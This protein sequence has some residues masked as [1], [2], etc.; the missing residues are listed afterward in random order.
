MTITF[1]DLATGERYLCGTVNADGTVT[2]SILLPGDNDDATWKKQLAWAKS[3]GG[4]LLN[5][6]EL[7]TAY[8]TM[9]EE[10]QKT[11]YWSNT[12]HAAYPDFAWCQDFYDG[13]QDYNGTNGMLRARAVR[14]LTI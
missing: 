6:V 11:W 7:V 2:Y 10:F 13:R 5:R 9:P 1:P 3:L 8:E 14:R 12:Q 4:D